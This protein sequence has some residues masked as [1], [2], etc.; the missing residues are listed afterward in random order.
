MNKIPTKEILQYELPAITEYVS[1]PFLQ[2]AIAWYTARKVHTKMK[3][4]EKRRDRQALFLLEHEVK[5]ASY[6]QL[7]ARYE[8][9][10]K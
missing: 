6:K 1:W 9:M 10:V 2:S 8:K 7:V 3:R 5:L 4:Y